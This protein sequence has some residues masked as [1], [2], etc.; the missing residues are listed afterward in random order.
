MGSMLARLMMVAALMVPCA[1][2]AAPWA[3]I[4]NYGDDTVS[5]LDTNT[6]AVVAVVPV[7]SSPYAVTVNPDGSRVYVTSD[8][9]GGTSVLDT[10]T[11]QVI[12]FIGPGARG[13]AV[14]PDGTRL[15]IPNYPAPTVSVVDTSTNE[16]IGD[17]IDVGDQPVGLAVTPD[18]SRVY[19]ANQGTGPSTVSVIDTASDTVI[20]TV[21]V[22]EGPAGVAITPD[23]LSV[24]VTNSFESSPGSVSVISTLSNTVVAT[25]PVG[26]E[27]QGITVTPNGLRVYVANFD[28]SGTED[29]DTVSVIDTMTNTVV[30]T[31][32]VGFQPLG[33]SVTP[34]GS[35]VYVADSSGLAPDDTHTVSVIDTA[36]DTVVATVSGFNSP[37]AFGQFIGSPCPAIPFACDVTGNIPPDRPSLTCEKQATSALLAFIRQIMGCH[38][39][40]A[41]AERM[42]LDFD[43]DTCD[44]LAAAK[45][46]TEIQALSDCPACLD[47]A[48]IGLGVRQILD[49]F[50]GLIYCAGTIPLASGDLGFVPPNA[51]TERCES[52][53]SNSL[54]AFAVGTFRCHNRRVTRTFHSRPYDNQRCEARTQNR[55]TR[56]RDRLERSGTCPACLN[57]SARD[58]LAQQIKAIVDASNSLTYCANCVDDTQCTAPQT[59]GGGGP[60]N[61]CGGP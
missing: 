5:V 32:P 60:G 40:N 14:T 47:S 12:G 31:I 22:G 9:G 50:N 4:T 36:T 55:V 19:V 46:D 42:E 34:D 44:T 10:A 6:N 7:L 59:C 38:D 24:Y 53:L 16:E 8:N 20:A 1:A 61:I 21:P 51:D 41:H 25:I 23:G 3:Y 49:R 11:N 37:F 2:A 13:V 43:E 30:A 35:R 26:E 54:K 29:P 52:L 45:L 39:A 15:Y 48:A 18:G 58:A 17:A 33:I 56:A 57:S 27:P 28:E